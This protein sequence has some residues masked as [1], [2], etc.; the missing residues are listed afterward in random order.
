MYQDE[1]GESGKQRKQWGKGIWVSRASDRQPS[2][3]RHY[4]DSVE[5]CASYHVQCRIYYYKT[6]LDVVP[7][8]TKSE[9]LTIKIV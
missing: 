9:G 1:L 3:T 2:E 6:G 7:N 5:N 4:R 8:T